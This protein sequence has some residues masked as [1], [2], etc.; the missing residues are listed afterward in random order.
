MYCIKVMEEATMGRIKLI[1]SQN[2]GAKNQ[3]SEVNE[4]S[5]SLDSK[6]RW[7]REYQMEMGGEEDDDDMAVDNEITTGQMTMNVEDGDHVE[8]NEEMT[9]KI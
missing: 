1:N 8:N 3:E 5:L 9:K 6:E 4:G 7:R 2:R